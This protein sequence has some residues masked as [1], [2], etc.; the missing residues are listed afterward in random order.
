MVNYDHY[1]GNGHVN[2]IN[3]L[4]LITQQPVF[5]NPLKLVLNLSFLCIEFCGSDDYRHEA[6][7]GQSG[8]NV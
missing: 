3:Q 7:G 6:A 8:E 4:V 1:S 5:L 2:Y